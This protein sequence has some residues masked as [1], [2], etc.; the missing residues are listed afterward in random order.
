MKSRENETPEEITATPE[1]VQGRKLLEAWNDIEDKLVKL[2]A[3]KAKLQEYLKN[4]PEED[5][6]KIERVLEE[7][8]A[9][10][11]KLSDLIRLD[12]IIID[13]NHDN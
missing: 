6:D 4:A 3:G 9:V 13:R 12:D 2:E 1:E 8:D 11:E 7:I 5:K 10:K